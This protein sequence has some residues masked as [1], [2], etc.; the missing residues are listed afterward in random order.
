MSCIS[1]DQKAAIVSQFAR[2]E[3]DTGSPEV[4]IAILSAEILKINEKYKKL[5]NF[6]KKCGII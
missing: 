2:A 6:I 4:Q 1:K 5:L 3:G